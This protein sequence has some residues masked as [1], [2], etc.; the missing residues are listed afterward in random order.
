MSTMVPGVYNYDLFVT[1]NDGNEY[2]GNQIQR[3]IKGE[4]T[5]NQRVTVL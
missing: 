5:V 3:L 2:S 4:V 1:V